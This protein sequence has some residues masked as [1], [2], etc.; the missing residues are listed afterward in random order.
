MTS[1]SSVPKLF[2]LFFRREAFLPGDAD[3]R[4][5]HQRALEEGRFH[6]ERVAANLSD[7]VFGRVFPELAR[8]IAGQA[9]D[10]PLGEVRDA[11]LVVLYRL[12]FILYAEDRERS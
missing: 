7:L 2:I 5:L 8:A 6:Q 10:A 12:L 4:T 9:P 1:T 3:S 11:A